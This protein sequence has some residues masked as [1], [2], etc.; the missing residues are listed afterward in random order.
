MQ[1]V[2]LGT[3][4]VL[5]ACCCGYWLLWDDAAIAPGPGVPRS[6]PVDADPRSGADPTAP[7]T[8]HASAADDATTKPASIQRDRPTPTVP[9]HHTWIVRGQVMKRRNVR[10][11]GA[12]VQ[13]RCYAGA[14]TD[15]A[16]LHERSI[17]TTDDGTFEWPLPPPIGTVT[18]AGAGDMTEHTARRSTELVPRGDAPPQDLEIWVSPLDCTVTGTVHDESGRPIPDA[19]V[20]TVRNKRPVEADGSFA[21]AVAN[22]YGRTRVEAGAPGFATAR[23]TLTLDGDTAEAHFGLA[24]GFRIRGRVVDEDGAGVEGATVA[25]FFTLYDP[26]T[27]DA[28]GRFE[29]T[30]ADPAR[31]SHSLFARK[32]GYVEA[33]TQV[34][35][36]QPDSD[37]VLELRRGVRVHGRIFDPTGA[38]L[39]GAELYIGFSPN[40]YN[41]LDAVSDDD[42][43]FEFSAVEPG[44]Q[45][46]VT[47][48]DGLAPDTRVLEV[49]EDRSELAVDVQLRAGHFLAGV[50]VDA[51]GHGVPDILL[52]VLQRRPDSARHRSDR[53]EYLDIRSQT[54]SDG[55]FRLEGLPAGVLNLE[56]YGSSIKRQL[57]RDVAVDRGDLRI[58]VQHAAR[59]AGRVVDDATGE[60]VR[61]FRAHLFQATVAAGEE[62]VSSY[63]ATWVREGYRFQTTDGVFVTENEQFTAGAIS[64]VEITASGYAPTRHPR[65]V[66]ALDPDPDDCVIRLVR[67]GSI[68]GTVVAAADGQPIAGARI[69]HFAEERPPDYFDTEYGARI[70]ATSAAD[71]TFTLAD[72]PAGP[73]ALLVET[74]GR[75]SHSVGPLTIETGQAT[76]CRIEVPAAATLA[77]T[78]VDHLGQPLAR[79]IVAVSTERDRAEERTDEQGRFRIKALAPGTCWIQVRSFP[80]TIGLVI[81]EQL[82]L[83]GG[84]LNEVDLR[85]TD[86]GVLRISVTGESDAEALQV[87][88]RPKNSTSARTTFPGT[89]VGRTFTMHGLPPGDYHVTV[90]DLRSFGNAECT[91]DGSTPT[92]ITVTLKPPKR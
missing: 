74:E 86:A 23:Q 5:A 72:L 6:G 88:V 13:L 34:D 21:F 92:E 20:G 35:G 68:R 45:T 77:G 41:R 57:T 60:P 81:H 18:I 87:A 19:W 2:V 15:G 32:D 51:E 53:G 27:S 8:A 65:V 30:H 79:A 50:V 31:N 1:K 91:I 59:L 83:V 69:V 36:K 9:A 71:G 67:G 49:P 14:T 73:A 7:S 85:P 11:P 63:S 22:P 3:L 10:Y 80:G 78:V 64:G 66:A 84:Q 48:R 47:S 75:P 26:T 16:P 56:A 29:I 24:P 28:A 44:P 70:R 40:A 82:E 38:P 39:A 4:A 76:D 55:S 61:D 25:T 43:T 17:T 46:L 54:G 12:R 37:Y 90:H 89:C 52:S 62:A 33:K 42:G 58:V